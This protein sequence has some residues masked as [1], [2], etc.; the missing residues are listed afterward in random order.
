VHNRRSFPKTG[1]VFCG[2]CLLDQTRAQAQQPSR[3]PAVVVSGKRVKTIDIHS[4][5][6][7]RETGALRGD[8]APSGANRG[9]P[10]RAG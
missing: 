1:I 2:G 9:K 3:L 6:H 10:G 8:Q 7:F 5:C 4:H